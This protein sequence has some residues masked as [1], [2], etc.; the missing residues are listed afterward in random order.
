MVITEI[1]NKQNAFLIKVF[2]N[3]EEATL[4]KIMVER[5][6]KTLKVFIKY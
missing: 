3:I 4:F 5:R 2:K 6:S 1:N